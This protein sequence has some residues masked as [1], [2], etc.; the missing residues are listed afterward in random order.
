MIVSEISDGVKI[1]DKTK[2]TCLATDW[3]RHGIG[4][5]LFQKYCSCP[6]IGLFCCRQGWKITL[7]GS[8]FTHPAE[9]RYAPIEGEAL[10]VADALDKARHFVL[11]CDNL[12]VAVDHKPLLKIFGDRSL[13]QVSNPRLR[14]LKEKTLRYS[15][16]MVHIPGVK[17]RA[18]DAISRYPSGDPIPS[19]MELSDDDISYITS[20]SLVSPGLNIPLQLFA[21]VLCDDQLPSDDMEAAL[22]HSAAAQLEDIQIV[23]WNQV[24]IATSSDTDMHSLLSIIENGMPDQRCQLPSQLRDYHQF[25][26]HLYSIDGVILYKDRI[27]IPP[28]LRQRCLSALHAAHQGTSSMISRADASIF[29]PG[30]T[31]DIQATRA[32]CSHCNQMAPSQPALPPTP[33]ILAVYPFQC[34]CADYFHQQGMNYLVIVDRYSNWPIVERVQ[35][36]SEGLI[37]VLR[38]TFATY[39]IPD[40]LSSDG[41]PEFVSH[42]TRSFLSS[43]D[44][45]HRLSSVA[46]PHS[47]CRA[48]VGVKTIK[49]LIVDNVGPGG[50]LDVDKF[51]QAILQYRN[52]PD[53]DTKL[54]PAI[55]IFGRP[56]KDL[57][58]ILPGKYQPH[59]VWKESLLAREA[60][61]RKRHIANHERW[62]EHTRRLPPLSVGDHVRIQ[63]QVGNHPRKWDKTG[64]VIEVRQYHQYV[65]RV[66]GSGRITIRNRK[67]LRKYTPVYKP[68][69]KRLILDDLKYLPP[70]CSAD[71]SPSTSTTHTDD[72]PIHPDVSSPGNSPE[73]HIST[74][75]P[76]EQDQPVAPIPPQSYSPTL[77]PRPP[78]TTP[79]ISPQLMASPQ[80]AQTETSPQPPV[81]PQTSPIKL[82]RSTQIKQPP[83]W[84]TSED[85]ILY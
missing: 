83:K 28:S 55:C 71:Q 82:R 30:I 23:D 22:R 32:N 4:F 42:I 5:W 63:N 13:D 52:T 6:S 24:R 25:K 20:D 18:S 9:S 12:V 57:I 73:V 15:F 64:I 34:I 70:S 11:G 61:L 1:F 50:N 8:R 69:R 54:S 36:G 80:P 56:I 40:E 62:Q 79:I 59:P 2:P 3:S 10:A 65:V 17:N 16:K 72:V 77:S 75:P 14:N 44:V 81:E 76:V 48:E 38:R 78:S 47:N 84:Q 58:P 27:V 21:G 51:Q 68:D 60:A 37:V 33:P 74:S 53:K 35:N 85:I 43:W 29:W 46:F 49:R 45:H 39:G 66:D 67:F 31:Y 26:E 19:K 41:G 7:V